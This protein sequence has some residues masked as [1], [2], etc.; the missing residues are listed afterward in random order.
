MA[1]ATLPEKRAA[2][3][4][5]LTDLLAPLQDFQIETRSGF[6][7]SCTLNSARTEWT[8]VKVGRLTRLRVFRATIVLP[9]LVSLFAQHVRLENRGPPAAKA[10]S[11]F[12][13]D[14]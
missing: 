10:E 1:V 9:L 12:P 5:Q 6:D 4:R 11:D 2:A 7:S 14:H 8:R 13:R 3:D